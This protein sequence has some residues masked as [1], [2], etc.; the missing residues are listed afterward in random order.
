MT[1][2]EGILT[3]PL[4]YLAAAMGGAVLAAVWLSLIVWTAKDIRLRSDDRLAHILAVITVALLAVPGLI[5]YLLL[6]PRRTMEEEYQSSLEEEALLA[7]IAGRL[8]CPGC[9]RTVDPEW[10]ICP[11][12]STLLRKACSDCGRMLE[13]NWNVCPYCGTAASEE[14]EAPPEESD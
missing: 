7:S 6:R 13:L 12:C 5:L 1:P 14:S 2:G 10:R 4:A 3:G 11:S 9:G 8:T